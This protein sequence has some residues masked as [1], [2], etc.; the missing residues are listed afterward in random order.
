MA[1]FDPAKMPT[2]RKGST[3]K[4]AVITWQT[5]IGVKADGIFGSGTETA[6]KAWQTARKLT[7][8]G[9]VGQASWKA[10]AALPVS[11]PPSIVPLPVLIVDRYVF[12]PSEFN[13]TIWPTIRKGSTDKPTVTMWQ[14]IIGVTADGV[15]GSGTEAATKAWQTARGLTADGIVGPLS[16]HAVLRK[17]I[18]V[19][20]AIATAPVAAAPVKPP[21]I[22]SPA[23]I[24]PPVV[25]VKLPL[26]PAPTSIAPQVTTPNPIQVP[27]AIAAPPATP[28]P[29]PP[30]PPATVPSSPAPSVG[31]KREIPNWQKIVGGAVLAFIGV[32]GFKKIR[33][34][35]APS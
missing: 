1:T 8:D 5:I 31:S 16:W 30:K 19:P 4:D 10:A 6:T 35:S 3:A 12:D 25:T 24:N 32:L 28:P 26:P 13:P 21:V 14:T 17:P 7:A 34:N 2:I 33:S 18:T 27:A 11:V 20:P 29:S 22:S 9:I 23:V 15:F